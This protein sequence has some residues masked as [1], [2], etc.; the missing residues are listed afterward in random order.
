MCVRLRYRP[1]GLLGS[2]LGTCR[3][4][5]CSVAA[6]LVYLVL[7]YLN[8]VWKTPQNDLKIKLSSSTEHLPH[9]HL[10]LVDQMSHH[11][12]LM[13]LFEIVVTL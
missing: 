5:E 12:I 2:S 7:F 13:E 4:A 1:A 3:E 6:F 11:N 10:L 8:K 9:E